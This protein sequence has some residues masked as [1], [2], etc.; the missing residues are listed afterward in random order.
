MSPRVA[1]KRILHGDTVDAILSSKSRYT[2]STLSIALPRLN[3][4][5]FI[6]FCQW[7][8]RSMWLSVF[9]YLVCHIV[10]IRAEKKVCGIAARRIVAFM[11]NLQTFGYGAMCQYPCD[12]M[13]GNS[14][15][16]KSSVPVTLAALATLPLPTIVGAKNFYLRPKMLCGWW[17]TTKT[18]MVRVNKP[19]GL[20]LD[21][22]MTRF[23]S[24]GNWSFFAATTA[25]V[26]SWNFKRWIVGR[27]CEK[28]ELWG[29]I[30][31]SNSLLRIAVAR[32]QDAPTSLAISIPFTRVSIAQKSYERNALVAELSAP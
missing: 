21:M 27:T 20:P 8:F 4:L 18:G 17:G 2:D 7:N 22:P 24:S 5:L 28:R 32:S 1:L 26:S 25:P 6:E 16:V 31:H 9:G 29:S 23:V 19:F 14:M 15:I 12:T 13:S 11:K 3:N 10:S 30:I